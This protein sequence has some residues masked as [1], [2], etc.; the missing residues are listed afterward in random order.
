MY[1]PHQAAPRITA[2]LGPTNTGK[3]HLAVERMLGH[4]SGMIGLPLRLLAREVYDRIVDQ[5]GKGAVALITGEEKLVPESPRYFV[6]TV[7]AMPLDRPVA[8]L[9]VDEIQLAADPARGHVFTQ[10]LLH[11]RGLEETMFLGAETIRPLI[12][13]LVPGVEFIG[14]PRLSTLSYAG[15]G[16]LTRLAPRS[17]IVSFSAASVYAL[18][19]YLR[20]RR[21]GAAVVLG[22]LSPRT[23]NAQVALYQAGEVDYMVATDAIGMGL[24]MDV[25]HVAFASLH[26]F[27]GR[28]ERMLMAHEVAQIAGRAGR[29]MNDGTFGVTGDAG[30]LA[31]A[32]VDAVENHRF[33]ALKAINW[34]NS[35]LAFNSLR[36][37]I[38]SLDEPPPTAGLIR[39]SDADD[40]LALVTLARDSEIADLAAG[41]DAVTLLWEV[42]R[43]P[44]YQKIMADDH[45]HL[46]GRIY[47]HLMQGDGCL[48]DDWVDGLV[49]R[50]DRTDGDI[51]T[52]SMRIAHVRTWTYVSHRTGWLADGRHWQERTR[53]I[54]DR[55]SDALHERLTQRFIDRRT[56]VLV[57][58]MK[59]DHALGAV[60]AEDGGVEV[61]GHFIGRLE[62]FRFVADDAAAGHE[63]RALWNA[64]RRA[65]G[66]EIE[67]RCAALTESPNEAFGVD[68]RA[69][70]RWGGAPVARLVAGADRLSPRVEVI[71]SELLSPVLRDRVAHRVEA[72]LADHIAAGLGHLLKARASERLDGPAR[73]LVYQLAE[74]LGAAPR[75][76]ASREVRALAPSD[77]KALAAL[78]VRLGR[79][80][81]FFPGM[82]KPRHLV[83]RA[84]LW[85][86]SEGAT[87]VPEPPVGA[88]VSV[89]VE[90][91]LPV[92]FY[93][94][95]GYRVF[96]DLAVRIDIVERVASRAH[97]LAAAGPFAPGPELF[98]LAGCAAE[99][100]GPLLGGLGFQ[101]GE[102]DADG[103]VRYGAVVRRRRGK[104]KGEPR[105]SGRKGDPDS[106]FAKLADLGLGS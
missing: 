61:E 31:A 88:R 35:R 75:R 80:S 68:E 51:D 86:V 46:L 100:L 57:R 66:S 48:P 67:R 19:D 16:K 47:R 106:P 98:A 24:N 76:G 4:R 79:E 12:R 2:V 43:I 73:G 95:I 29:H 74:G 96:G 102:P 50:L 97:R 44:D 23:R 27:D 49:K 39:A 65:L 6:C 28:N 71:E 54:E 1:A 42:C 22:A 33:P 59:L 85:A 70:V 62:G 84:L 69:R 11:A 40:Y 63:E 104:A 9:V 52:L 36:A 93:A 81:I 8:C 72:W 92:S 20:H 99:A 64:A 87:A 101:R 30:P 38:G 7:E 77:R 78:G 25:D 26:K 89:P 60:V 105:P 53:A 90:P 37:L 58:R 55:L 3:T 32:T 82:L 15:P 21:G 17:A 83:V 103:V 10:R 41:P 45:A 5:A 94:A 18:A 91:A 13:R 34:R 14:R 56:A